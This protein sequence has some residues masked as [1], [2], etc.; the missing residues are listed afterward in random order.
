MDE[1]VGMLSVAGVLVLGMWLVDYA[2]DAT[3]ASTVV[4]AASIEAAHYAAT[5]V[6]SSQSGDNAEELHERASEVAERMVGAATLGDCDTTDQRYDVAADVHRL[7]SGIR[8]VA[9]SVGV[10]CPLA[11][12]PLFRDTIN[13]RVAVPIL[14]APRAPS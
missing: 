8:P 13:T 6:S 1:T 12:S 3:R 7:A 14:S 11:V 2:G 4:R 9:V 5:V 10:V